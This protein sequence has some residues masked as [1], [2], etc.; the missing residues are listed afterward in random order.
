MAA[1]DDTEMEF[2]PIPNRD[3]PKTVSQQE[4]WRRD[5]AS[6]QRRL[7]VAKQAIRETISEEQKKLRAIRQR[8]RRAKDDLTATLESGSEQA[9][10]E[11]VAYMK[12]QGK[13]RLAPIRKKI[14]ALQL[15]IKAYPE[16]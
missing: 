3:I 8:I 16:G 12:A 15:M 14:R 11:N 1:S 5:V 7:G 6:L 2:G 9:I 13:L 10:V 4:A